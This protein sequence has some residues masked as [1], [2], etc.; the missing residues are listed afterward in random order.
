LA[1]NKRKILESAQKHLQKGAVDKALKEYQAL[2]KADP[3]DVN[4]RLKVGDLQLR[5]GQNEEAIEAYLKVAERFM[6]DGFDAKAV[7]LYKQIGRLDPKRTEIHLPLAELYQRL[8]LPS[9]AMGALQ[10]AAD[11][12]FKAGAKAAGLELMRRMAALDPTNTTN[13]LKVAELL[14]QEGMNAEAAAEFEAV[15]R[16]FEAQG[17]AEGTSRALDQVL[18]VAPDRTDLSARLVRACIAARRLP[19]ALQLAERSVAAQPDSVEAHELLADALR[20]CGREDALP[21]VYRRLAALYK[22]RGDEERMR[23]VLQRFV[24]G[25]VGAT[26]GEELVLETDDDLVLE[27]AAG[28]ELGSAQPDAVFGADVSLARPQRPTPGRDHGREVRPAVRTEHALPPL[29]DYGSNDTTSPRRT[30]PSMTAPPGL[31]APA[32]SPAAPPA[33]A[34]PPPQRRAPAPAPAPLPPVAAP[35]VAVAV[36]P[37]PEASVAEPTEEEAAFDPDQLL[38]EANVYL[39]YGKHERAVESLRALLAQRPDHAQALVK[40]GDALEAVGQRGEAVETLC[41]AARLAQAAG[42]SAPFEALRTRIAALDAAAAG[43]LD[44]PSAADDDFLDDVDIDI[45]ADLGGD[46]GVFTDEV[47][48]PVATELERDARPPLASGKAAP[49]PEPV[50]EIEVS[51]P[52]V[53]ISET[54][55]GLADEA[56]EPAAPEAAEPTLPQPPRATTSEQLAAV[57]EE[58]AF[59][60]GQGML[61]EAEDV[62]RRILA[63]VPEQPLALQRLGEI[64]AARAALAAAAPEA[65]AESESEPADEPVV[66][67]PSADT[68]DPFAAPALPPALEITLAPLESPA[69]PLPE[70]DTAE[71]GDGADDTQSLPASPASQEV[72]APPPLAAAPP[73]APPVAPA[74]ATVG[75]PGT[76]FEEP[77]EFDL[78]KAISD[79]LV[80][81]R[82]SGPASRATRHTE[83][84]GI[85]EVFAAFKKGV[86][87]TLGAEDHEARYDLG[88][89]Y[90]EMGLLEDALEAFRMALSG[91]SRRLDCL[92]MMGLCALDL[93]RSADAV[94]HLE[95]ALS[96]A[97]VPV[98]QQ[99]ALRFDLARAYESQGDAG[100]ALAAFEAVAAEDPGFC[101]VGE[102]IAAL[103]GAVP[104]EAEPEREEEA[105][106]SFDDLVAEQAPAAAE[107]GAPDEPAPEPAPE[108]PGE[109]AA[110]PAASATP[111]PDDD[112]QIPAGRPKPARTGKRKKISFF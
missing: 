52:D 12:Q 112:T 91:P 108:A 7:A 57:L 13:R 38:A 42:H 32:S 28:L 22:E 55:I 107:P 8:G 39:R 46:E 2:L 94:A 64:E 68:T 33:A 6:A 95:Q 78:G 15:A 93:G 48:A 53:E 56:Q 104:G 70:A 90:R 50:I 5:L 72:V 24:P 62:C 81:E 34:L 88:I 60:Q 49:P 40:L 63:A 10:A 83:G 11:A 109:E 66:V 1:V 30:P 77:G 82:A 45:E 75:A 61:D 14:R 105:L 41:K 80:D 25:A 9:D 26:D 111:A 31:A 71:P 19:Q 84:V 29:P 27:D 97:D 3:K 100:R 43:T 99:V 106:E 74:V 54:E 98:Q 69:E 110:V 58:A 16:E 37:G 103:R 67:E 85:E 76:A 89:A 23:D 47:P 35:P 102:R 17:D 87:K 86:E 4:V 92:H 51:E 65:E 18:V 20:A 73:V 101:D 79:T 21:D 59:Y 96:H 36:L 44:A